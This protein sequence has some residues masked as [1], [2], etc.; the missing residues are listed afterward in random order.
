MLKKKFI[1][2]SIIFCIA[3]Y[4]GFLVAKNK[5]SL[6]ES[7]NK[8][9]LVH[10]YPATENDLINVVIE[11]PAGSQDKWEVDKHTG[12][13]TWEIRNGKHRKVNY[14]AYPAN[15][16]MIPRTLLPRELGGDGDP[17][18]VIILGNTLTQGRIVQARPIGILKLLD[19]G[20]ID[21]KIIAVLPDS[22]FSN[23]TDIT[24][25]NSLFPGSLNIIELWFENYKEKGT[26]KSLGF[27]TKKEAQ[28]IIKTASE[29][30][31]KTRK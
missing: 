17:L 25:L 11:I 14:L 16:G 22:N 5:D 29:S 3:F 6:F 21:D 1:Q 23:V 24:T 20:E 26:M 9:H 18:D 2:L 28:F 31:I 4:L 7:R 27:Q 19:H 12:K 15:Y 10:D 30:Y 13:L 8:N